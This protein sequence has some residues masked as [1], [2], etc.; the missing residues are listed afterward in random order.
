MSA[1]ANRFVE[2]VVLRQS[3]LRL[4]PLALSHEAGLRAAAA[5]GELWQLRVTSVPEPEQ[6]RAYIEQALQMRAAGSRIAFAVIDAV[7]NTVLG[8]PAMR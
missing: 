5:D 3:G 8:T 1:V 6:T 2:P 4:E 7:S